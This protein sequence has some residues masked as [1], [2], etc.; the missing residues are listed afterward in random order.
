MPGDPS[1]LTP[2][3]IRLAFSAGVELDETP[4][5]RIVDGVEYVV[6]K[7]IHIFPQ[8]EW[9]AVDGRNVSFTAQD[10][11]ALLSE[12][13]TR[14]TDVALTY[15]HEND[16]KRGSEA[17]GWMPVN[18][19]VFKQ[20]GLW[21]MEPLW[22]KDVYEKEIKTGK[23]RYLSGDALGTGTAKNGDAF[24]PRRLL[25]AS[26][27][28]KPGFVRGLSGIQLSAEEK[29]N[30]MTRKEMCQQMGVKEDSTIEELRDAFNKFLDQEAGEDEHTQLAAKPP[31]HT[32]AECPDPTKCDIHN[33]EADEPTDEEDK[34]EK[35]GAEKP[36][37]ADAEV[38]EKFAALGKEIAEKTLASATDAATKAAAEHVEKRF[39]AE[40]AAELVE[41]KI[42]AAQK[43]GRLQTEKVEFARKAFG[44]STEFGD[45]F[46]SS[47]PKPA[48]APNEAVFSKNAAIL[49][50]G[51]GAVRTRED[52][53]A[54][55]T[56]EDPR[57]YSEQGKFLTSVA[58]FAANTGVRLDAAVSA[59][60]AGENEKLEEE[61]F[62]A[63]SKTAEDY[64]GDHV[65][66]FRANG[67]QI[68]LDP[69]MVEFVKKQVRAGRVPDALIPAEIQQFASISDF[70]PSARTTLPMALGF[71]QAEFVGDE[72]LPVFVGG[73]DEKA[74]WPEFAFE[75]FAA[76][77]SAAGLLGAPTR[78]SL[79]VT[80]HTV[81]LEKFPVQIDIDRRVRAAS[82][83]LP[84]GID[85]IALEN[86]KSQV[87]VTKELAQNALL[88]TNGNYYDNTF[89]PTISTPWSTAGTPAAYGGLPITDITAGMQ[90]VRV[91]VRRWPDTLLLSPAA[92]TAMRKN[93]QI[94]DTV[95]Y[96]G[97]KGDP[98]TM[99]TNSQLAAVFAGLFNIAIIVGEAGSSSLPSGSPVTDVW[100]TDAWLVCTGKGEI[101]APRF[102]M[103]V[104]SA[105]SP[106]VRSFPTEQLGADGSDSIV[107]TDSWSVVSVNKKAAYWMKSAAAAI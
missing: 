103:T 51:N 101:E 4:E 11:N 27:V 3:Q 41:T 104:A 7:P 8:G 90:H 39:A 12:V 99:L 97:T 16:K 65:G 66:Q 61:L 49:G 94:I 6:G 75:K 13:K 80:W 23:F 45:E 62:A 36:K 52:L 46:L 85:T 43:D 29:E 91:A 96:T 68:P 93:Q 20:D 102:G 2:N 48:V 21:N 15:D 60:L 50:T 64:T 34:E 84:R 106:R 19:F 86:L 77:A 87:G 5:L 89:Y 42:S 74:A 82:V 107:Y 63:G 70:Q 54:L 92:A 56:S 58:R 47:L 83:T 55:M 73:A 76:I 38:S 100:G 88:T 31:E 40:K 35:M 67:R 18:S 59:V 32:K 78:S 69:E 72:V 44:V 28:P 9:V 14:Q 81:T 95:R 57:R 37:G 79:N 105:G 10:A 1:K 22:V 30:T 53:K 26:L 71:V 24:H 33:D 17:A 98:G 25:A